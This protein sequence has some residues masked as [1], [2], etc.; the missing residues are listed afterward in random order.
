MAQDQVHAAAAGSAVLAFGSPS[1]G[2]MVSCD[3]NK[4]SLATVFAVQGVA[5]R[6][7][8][9]RAAGETNSKQLPSLNC[10][11]MIAGSPLLEG[12]EITPVI[13]FPMIDL[14]SAFTIFLHPSVA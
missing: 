6:E 11:T 3:V 4:G 12:W 9:R 10:R 14:A 7:T 13:V 8:A 5:W 1:R 2:K